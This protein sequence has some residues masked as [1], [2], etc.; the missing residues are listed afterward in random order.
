MAKTKDSTIITIIADNKAGRLDTFLA[1]QVDGYSRSFFH[2]LIQDGFV[3][4][5][6]KVLNPSS[7]VK[8]NDK[9]VLEIVAPVSG[10]TSEKMKLDSKTPE[11]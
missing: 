9:I 3:T 6:G 5:N 7:A 4:A 2:R 10:V 1:A 8:V 11:E